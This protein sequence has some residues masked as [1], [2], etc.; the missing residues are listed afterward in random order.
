MIKRLQLINEMRRKKQKYGMVTACVGF[1]QGVA[2]IYEF[3]N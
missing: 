3:L 1:G 2:G